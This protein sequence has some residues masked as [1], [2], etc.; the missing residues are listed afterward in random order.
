MA[1]CILPLAKKMKAF[2]RTR[3]TLRQR[4][5]WPGISR[6]KGA[7]QDWIMVKIN[8]ED[9]LGS[10][11]RNCMVKFMM[12]LCMCKYMH[13]FYVFLCAWMCNPV[14][15]LIVGGQ[16][17]AFEHSW[18]PKMRMAVLTSSRHESPSWK[19]EQNGIDFSVPF[20]FFLTLRLLD[21][22]FFVV[23]SKVLKS[24]A[25]AFHSYFS[26]CCQV[27]WDAW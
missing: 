13:I 7:F 16:L 17:K 9:R 27:L 19:S 21:L 24:M 10:I 14:I 20:V 23:W 26:S 8:T 6:N 4:E 2:W 18:G 22:I 25:L 11:F 15:Y 1:L 5:I 12:Y 3:V